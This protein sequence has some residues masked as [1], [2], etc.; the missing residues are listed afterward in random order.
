MKFCALIASLL[1]LCTLSAESKQAAPVLTAS[2]SQIN[3]LTDFDEAKAKASAESKPIFLYFTGSDWC[4]WCKQ[5]DEQILSTPEFQQV[6]ANKII[7]VKID[8]PRKKILHQKEIGQNERLATE[9]NI[10][11]F[12]TVILLD[13]HEQQIAMLHY[14][15]GDGASFAIMINKMLE[16]SNKKSLKS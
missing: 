6:L 3:W 14:N 12:P 2:T 1:A 11:G 15:G 4:P 13:S 5:M 10:N 7:F 16:N 8:F 9:Y